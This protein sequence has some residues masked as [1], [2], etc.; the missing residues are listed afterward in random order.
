ME[1]NNAWSAHAADWLANQAAAK[2]F[3]AAAKGI[4]ELIEPD[5]G[6]AYGHG[7]E[8]KRSG[9]GLSIKGAK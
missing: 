7:I 3:D 5:V 2:K 8:V 9:R 4:K 1:G 6:F